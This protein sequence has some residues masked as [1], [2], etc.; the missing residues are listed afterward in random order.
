[1]NEKKFFKLNS[2][3]AILAGMFFVG[4]V[5]YHLMFPSFSF[6][7]NRKN[8]NLTQAQKQAIGNH[9]FV[10]VHPFK[11]YDFDQVELDFQIKENFLKEK[12]SFQV[13]IFKGF[14]F[15]FFNLAEEKI[16]S[17]EKLKEF[18]FFGKEKQEG[19]ANGKL[20][21]FDGGVA[22]I[23]RGALH[24]FISPEIFERMGFNWEDVE[25]VDSSL[26]EGMESGEKFNFSNTVHLD[27]TFVMS[28]GKVYLVWEKKLLEIS[29]PAVVEYV[30]NNFPLIRIAELNPVSLG[31]CQT[32]LK[33][34]KRMDCLAEINYAESLQGPFF[35]EVDE[36]GLDNIE[37]V[38]IKLKTRRN[39][40][41]KNFKNAFLKM[42][43][44]IF[45]EVKRK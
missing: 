41:W 1:M 10:S 44:N 37:E 42:A 13:I 12:S 2:F 28:E 39:F 4:F 25:E 34:K 16:D 33:G 24:Y 17:L 3:F 7:V 40:Y 21:S 31:S 45:I 38:E 30:K 43:K 8:G 29:D 26:I 19:I 11:D 32:I 18:L 9:Q 6:F 23:S 20:I 27:G 5:F 15:Q 14:G 22:F 35:F 36:V